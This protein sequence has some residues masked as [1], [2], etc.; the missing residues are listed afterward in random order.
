MSCSGRDWEK[1]ASLGAA[2]ASARLP[3]PSVMPKGLG[4]GLGGSEQE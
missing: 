2:G 1:L 3:A 4:G